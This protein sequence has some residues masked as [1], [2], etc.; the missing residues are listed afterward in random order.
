MRAVLE[1]HQVQY[2]TFGVSQESEAPESGRGV[3]AE[4]SKR[5]VKAACAGL[6]WRVGPRSAG[7][8]QGVAIGHRREQRYG[9]CA[10]RGCGCVARR[11]LKSCSTQPWRFA[12]LLASSRG[13][14][15]R[16]GDWPQDPPGAKRERHLYSLPPGWRLL[17][18]AAAGAV[19]RASRRA[20]ACGAAFSRAWLRRLGSLRHA[21][22]FCFD[23]RIKGIGFERGP[24]CK[25]RQA[26]KASTSG[27]LS[28]PGLDARAC[29]HLFEGFAS[30]CQF[31]GIH[32]GVLP[33][34][35]I[36]RFEEKGPEA[37]SIYG[38]AF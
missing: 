2:K 15:S 7:L 4:R 27:R 28:R 33:I 1:L 34:G 10:G 32:F 12:L 11:E 14:D 38:M 26:T 36:R 23:A 30:V 22:G 29:T 37:Y 17:R 3:R 16:E 18:S 35:D 19:G 25:R 21:L 6:A 31:E 5:H 9:W 8:T 13:G 20:A 24:K